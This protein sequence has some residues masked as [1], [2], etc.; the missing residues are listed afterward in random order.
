MSEDDLSAFTRTLFQDDKGQVQ[1]KRCLLKKDADYNGYGF[2]LRFH[3]GLHLIDRVEEDSPAYNAG[4][5]EDDV[6]IFVA[7]K[8]VEQMSHDDVR[9]LI[10]NVSSNKTPID[11]ILMKKNDTNRYKIYQEKNSIDWK[12]IVNDTNISEVNNKQ[13]RPIKYQ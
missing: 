11:L 6:I 2:L 4:L 1:F 7:K 12:P 3:N 5:R 8:N 10:K 9:T 13:S